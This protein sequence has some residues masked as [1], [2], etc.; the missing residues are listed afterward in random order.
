MMA[1]FRNPYAHRIIDP[2]PEVGGA[3]I[4]FIDLLLKTLDDIDWDSSEGQA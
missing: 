2:S 4:A 1:V 3:I